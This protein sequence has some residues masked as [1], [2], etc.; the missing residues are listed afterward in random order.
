VSSVGA[1]E[2][3]PLIADQK[4]F[5]SDRFDVHEYANAVL[6]G[7]AYRPDEP[8]GDAKEQTTE[9]GDVSTELAK[10]NYGIVRGCPPSDH[11]SS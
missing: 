7:R 3:H 8:N 2:D 11:P 9:R 10:L 4:P 5:L 6:A 1:R